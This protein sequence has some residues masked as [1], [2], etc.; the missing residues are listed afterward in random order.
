MKRL[1]EVEFEIGYI[2]GSERIKRQIIASTNSGA[3]LAFAQEL[4]NQAEGIKLQEEMAQAL[5]D[6][7]KGNDD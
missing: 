7:E 2:G 3:Y 6:S 4:I 1:F 5:Q